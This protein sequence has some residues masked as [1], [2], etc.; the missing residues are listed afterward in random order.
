MS[1]E[2]TFSPTGNEASIYQKL[3]NSRK[4]KSIQL[5]LFIF[6]INTS[7]FQFTKVILVSACSN[8][9]G[10]VLLVRKVELDLLLAA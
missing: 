2:R 1:T 10:F 9:F 7:L 3:G 4:I 5:F 6:V 8:I